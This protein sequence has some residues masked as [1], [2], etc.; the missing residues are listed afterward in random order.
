MI[1]NASGVRHPIVA[2]PAGHST[3]R[4]G[5][6]LVELLVVIGI[7]ALLI[8]ILLPSL[9]KAR[10]SAAALKSLSNVRQIGTAL[11]MYVNDN[12]G[13]YPR[14]S[15]I[16]S[17]TTGAT[18]P[19]A[20]TRWVDDIYPFLQSTEVFM[21]PLISEDERMRMRAPFAHTCDPATGLPNGGTLY[22]GG[23]GYNYQYLGNAR[24][25]GNIPTFHARTSQIRVSTQTIAVAD[26][27]GSK[28]GGTD[29]TSEGVYVID[30]PRMSVAYG[31]QGS[32]KSSA[33]P[34]G[35]QYAYTGG[36]DADPARRRTPA[37]RNRNRVNVA[38]CD[39]HAE[40]MTLKEMDDFDG[41]GTPDN[42]Y[43]NGLGNAAL[44]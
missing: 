9:S 7:I 27:N 22:F 5:F 1:I 14:H 29:W 3:R 10:E 34:G 31:S 24:R 41:N 8:S 11:I 18:P 25:P 33:T 38:F 28:N 16:V 6:T 26:S 32:R 20:R 13:Y 44:R 12:K 37:E 2:R 43:W 42:G 40:A 4:A 39:G 23:Y 21:S 35:G 19:R 36:S 30:P 17:E 15:S